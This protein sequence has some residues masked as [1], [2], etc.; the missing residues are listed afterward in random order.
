VLD[1][2]L[3]LVAAIPEARGLSTAGVAAPG[4]LDPREG[5]VLSMPNLPGFEDY[6]LR[7]A[8][9]EALGA[10]VFVHNDA[11]LAAL[12]ESRYGAG[13]GFDPLVYLTVSTGVGGGVVVGGEVLE[14]VSGLAGELG[15]VTID[16]DGPACN[17]GHRG[18]L[19]ALASGTAIGR[20][21][22]ERGLSPPHTAA[23]V[24]ALA[25]AGD[26]VAAEVFSCAGHYLGLAVGSFVNIFD[27]GRVVIGGGVANAWDLLAGAVQAGM[28]EIVMARSARRLEVVRSATG[29]DAGLLGAALYAARRASR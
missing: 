4:P 27:P 5:I 6:P 21:A 7:A 18:C 19:E 2:L 23:G 22:A 3:A 15:H 24:A 12:G 17:F 13:R 14:G 9:G 25:R 28:A 1:A 10:E 20:E 29:D 26:A 16:S 8:W 11:N